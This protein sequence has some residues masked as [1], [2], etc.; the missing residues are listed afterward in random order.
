M[1][2]PI[3]P[4]IYR[5]FKGGEYEVLELALHSETEQAHVVYRPLYGERRLWVRPLELFADHKQIDGQELAR[6]ERIADRPES[7]AA[8]QAQVAGFCREHG[9]QSPTA[10]RLLDLCSELGELAKLWLQ[11]SNYGRSAD[12]MLDR[13]AWQC[14]LGDVMFALLCLAN[15]TEVNVESALEQALQRYRNRI[16]AAGHPGSGAE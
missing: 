10:A 7:L 13:S 8:A 12:C 5:H 4:G 11:G 9:I 6:F 2:E 1:S 3:R 16:E 14:E 15:E